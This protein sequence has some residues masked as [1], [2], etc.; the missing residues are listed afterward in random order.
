MGSGYRGES[1]V[2]GVGK[3]RPRRSEAGAASA[4]SARNPIRYISSARDVAEGPMKSSR[5]TE[6]GK[7]MRARAERA[8]L[9]EDATRLLDELGAT[10]LEVAASLYSYGC[11]GRPSSGGDHPVARYLH[12]VVG[13]DSRVRRI[14]VTKGWLALET[15]RGRRATIWLRLPDSVREFTLMVDRARLREASEIPYEGNQA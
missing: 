9:R 11:K 1:G 4:A 15:H 3:V 10:A 6:K 14:K 13:T 2:T 5:R 7:H 12:A 8:V